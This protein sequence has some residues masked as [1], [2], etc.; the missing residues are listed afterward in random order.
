MNLTNIKI[1]KLWGSNS[2]D[3]KI[4]D[5][6]LIVVGENGSGKSTI[7]KLIYLFLSKQW[8][9]INEIQFEKIEAVID[10]K[11]YA[12]AKIILIKIK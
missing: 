6:V 8:E 3:I 4:K 11:S 1:T 5:N 12:L 7:L 2:Y 10:G 9:R